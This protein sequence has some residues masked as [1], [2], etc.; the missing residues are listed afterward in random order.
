[1]L[2]RTLTM[3]SFAQPAIVHGLRTKHLVFAVNVRT[4]PLI[5]HSH[6][7]RTL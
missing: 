3:F 5:S 2:L 4:Y 7:C 6:V 1:M